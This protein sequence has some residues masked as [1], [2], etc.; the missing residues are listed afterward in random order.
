MIIEELKK[1]LAL[2]CHVHTN[3]LICPSSYSREGKKANAG[4]RPP[5]KAIFRKRLACDMIV[6]MKQ[7]PA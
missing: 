1:T 5:A 6:S 4:R 2:C 3:H 7:Q